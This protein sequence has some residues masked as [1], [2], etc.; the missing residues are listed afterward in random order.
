MFKYYETEAL[1]AG[2]ARVAGPITYLLNE[3][4]YVSENGLLCNDSIANLQ[5]AGI[6]DPH[7]VGTCSA[8]PA[9]RNGNRLGFDLKY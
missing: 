1:N 9:T 3:P 6:T 5:A 2:G 4:L 7:T 8:I